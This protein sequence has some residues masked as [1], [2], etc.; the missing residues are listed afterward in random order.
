M[1]TAWPRLPVWVMGS[2]A[3]HIAGAAGSPQTADPL[4]DGRRFSHGPQAAIA[5][6]NATSTADATFKVPPAADMRQIR[7][8]SG[9]NRL[10]MM[11]ADCR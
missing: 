2:H 6:C 8:V 10:S 7:G 3:E 11:A 5:T 4:A 1:I 9:S